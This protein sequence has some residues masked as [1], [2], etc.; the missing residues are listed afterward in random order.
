MTTMPL[1]IKKRIGLMHS[2]SANDSDY[3]E[4]LWQFMEAGNHIGVGNE[5]FD[6]RRSFLSRHL[7][8]IVYSLLNITGLSGFSVLLSSRKLV[9]GIPFII[10]VQM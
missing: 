3:D 4:P 7:S 8:N 10:R 1:P 2:C 5:L 6:L 9:G